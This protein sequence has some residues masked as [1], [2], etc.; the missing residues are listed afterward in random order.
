M[1]EV[2]SSVATLKIS[3]VQAVALAFVTYYLGVWIKSKVALL[4]KLSL[5]AAVI[6]GLPFA[7][8]LSVLRGLGILQVT[9]DN[10]LSTVALLAFFTTVGM[11]ASLKLVKYGGIALVFFWIISTIVGFAQN[12][13]GM[14]IAGAM[15]IDPHYGIL[16]GAV[17][18]MGGLGTSAAFGPYFETT[19]GIQGSTSVAITAAT[20]GMVAALV[21]GGPFGEWILNKY[22]IDPANKPAGAD[23]PDAVDL[24]VLEEEEHSDARGVI[25]ASAFVFLAIGIGSVVSAYLGQLITLPAYIGAMLIAAV[26]RNIGDFSGMYK[27]QG[28]GLNIVAEVALT[29]YV[30]MA[31]NSL[32][33]YELIH[34]ALPLFIILVAQT[35]FMLV[36]A[37][38][39]YFRIF[40][41]NY[42]SMMLAVGAIGFAMGATANGLANMQA[43][44]DKHGHA[45]RAWLIV[46]LVGAFLIDFTN[47]I[48]ITWMGAW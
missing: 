13:I 22:N 20:F 48:I 35:V 1:N 7:F 19:Y 6:G 5:P 46:S 32:N 33:L 4:Q 26:I 28:G 2:A 24:T 9:F 45:P 37:W 40:G 3:S 39:V 15:G 25:K 11:M 38:L 34:L 21:L 29:V 47:A 10:S 17:S 44:G 14:G 41:K 36:V 27:V 42:E 8:F 31:I 43:I 30:T 23:K 16:A 18:L 12:L